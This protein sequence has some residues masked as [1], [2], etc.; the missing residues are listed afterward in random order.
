M[1][2]M[3]ESC[4]LSKTSL[5]HPH[6]K[7][8]ARALLFLAHKKTAQ[9]R[10]KPLEAAVNTN[11]TI[12]ETS[13]EYGVKSYIFIPCVVYGKGEGFGNKTSIQTVAIVNA[14]KKTGRVYRPNSE[15]FVC[16]CYSILH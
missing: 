11:N 3:N 7:V 4:M 10:Y 1:L 13:L 16:F 6:W 12:I 5:V 9:P 8:A 14:A 15:D 2:A